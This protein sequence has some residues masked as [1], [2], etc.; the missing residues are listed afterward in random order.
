MVKEEARDLTQLYGQYTDRS[1]GS[2]CSLTV[3]LAE[4]TTVTGTPVYLCLHF[5][6][7]TENTV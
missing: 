2:W 1:Q 3:H 7:I 6:L 4:G 5:P